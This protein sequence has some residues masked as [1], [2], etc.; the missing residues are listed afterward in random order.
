[1]RFA[2]VSSPCGPEALQRFMRCAW[3]AEQR[4][5][6]LLE[7]LKVLEVGRMLGPPLTPVWLLT[8]A[9]LLESLAGLVSRRLALEKRRAALPAEKVDLVLKALREDDAH[10]QHVKRIENLLTNAGNPRVQDALHTLKSRFPGVLT[11]ADIKSWGRLRHPLAHGD[12][13]ALKGGG[14]EDF[15]RVCNAANKLVCLVLGYDGPYV[16]HDPASEGI[17]QLDLRGSA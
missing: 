7:E 2:I 12:M 13:H 16:D 14:L 5:P 10:R 6:G 4:S 1:M 17:R 3:A 11:E 15:F 8:A 9:V